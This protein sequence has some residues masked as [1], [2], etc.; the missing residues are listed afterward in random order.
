LAFDNACPHLLY[1]VSGGA[2]AE[3]VFPALRGSRQL[4][5]STRHSTF[6]PTSQHMANST[7]SES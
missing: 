1:H 6:I 7:D 2:A 4:P 3:G 5:L